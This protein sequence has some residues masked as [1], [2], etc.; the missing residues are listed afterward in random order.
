MS[1]YQTIPVKEIRANK[2]EE[3]D[4]QVE[5]LNKMCRR[6]KVKEPKV[7]ISEVYE[8][9][10]SVHMGEDQHGFAIYKNFIVDVFDTTFELIE[11]LNFKG[12][13]ELKGIIGHLEGFII[14]IDPDNDLPEEFDA[15]DTTCDHCNTRRRRNKSFLIQNN[16]GEWKRVGGACVKQFLGVNP[17]SFFKLVQAFREFRN[18]DSQ[19][20]EDGN[21]IPTTYQRRRW[22]PEL[23]AVDIDKLIS[24]TATQI[25]LDGEYIKNEWKEVGTGRYDRWGQEYMKMVRAN[26]GESTADNVRRTFDLIESPLYKETEYD[27]NEELVADV[28]KYWNSIEV[29]GR[30]EIEERWNFKTNEYEDVEVTHYSGY[31]DFLIRTKGYGEKKRI[32]IMDISK[33]IPSINSYFQWKTKQGEPVSEHIGTVGEKVNMEVTV[34]SV[35]GFNGTYGWTNIYKM[36]DKDHNQI[37]KFGTINSRYLVEG[38][39]IEEGSVLKFKAEIKK[40]DEF[41]GKKQTTIGRISKF[42]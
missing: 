40:H 5:K 18:I 8:K 41:R 25:E 10:Y 42:N 21:H 13:W 28:Y 6:L 19:Y 12:G 26:Q 38:D 30:T 7:H 24:M 37:T 36:V 15:N 11:T 39:E 2:R 22:N 29:K 33:I 3:F 32:R 17:E 20:D 23:Q 27:I 34:T 31:E 9:A 4:K 16:E 1:E 14:P 35:S